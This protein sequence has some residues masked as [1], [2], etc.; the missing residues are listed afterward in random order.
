MTR[1]ARL[2]SAVALGA[3]LVLV[4]GSA[5]PATT[6]APARTEC[7]TSGTSDARVG[8]GSSH[9]KDPNSVT[10]AEAAAAEKDLQSRVAGLKRS[11]ALD[12]T[13]APAEGATYRVKTYVHVITRA[14]GTGGVTAQQ[15]RDQLRVL[16]RAYAG[17]TSR[18]AA[19]TGF[20]FVLAGLDTVANDDWFDWSRS[21][22]DD[23]EAK[24]ALRRGGWADLNVYVAGLGDGLL[25][26]ATFPTQGSLA[27]DGVVL[28][29]ESLPGGSAAPYNLGDTGTHEVGHW[30]GLFHTFQDGCR[31]GDKVDDTPAQ[32][33]GENIFYC[34]ES[35][36]T[37]PAP[38]M[39]PV[40]NFMSYGDDPCLDQFTAGQA[41]RM[42]Q[43]WLAY[44]DGR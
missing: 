37:C 33:A 22:R 15:V 35:D 31:D 28:L 4:P 11:G 17:A 25:G 30:L 14:D 21:D 26:Y 34:N 39:D 12:A 27:R 36:D 5:A 43:T 1:T 8:Y 18:A 13:G 24:K 42:A 29:N 38:G 2:F 3:A 6:A 19:D 44:R 41:T 7:H 10:A 32:A 40:H 20:E 23:L 16:N 9:G